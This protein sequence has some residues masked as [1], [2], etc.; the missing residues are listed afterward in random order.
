M[1][2]TRSPPRTYTDPQPS[3]S[4]ARHNQRDIPGKPLLDRL[5]ENQDSFIPALM[6]LEA[7]SDSL[8]RG[9]IVRPATLGI[10]PAVHHTR[11]QIQQYPEYTIEQALVL[12][13]RLPSPVP[14]ITL[15]SASGTPSTYAPVALRLAGTIHAAS[16]A[17]WLQ[18]WEN[19]TPHPHR[20]HSPN[21][22]HPYPYPSPARLPTYQTPHR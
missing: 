13:P 18:T 1:K 14:P 5:N 7:S 16:C 11:L 10:K 2:A 6:R 12:F 17:T 3:I 20:G 22:D 15:G 21:S 4:P 9:F 19:P 8:A